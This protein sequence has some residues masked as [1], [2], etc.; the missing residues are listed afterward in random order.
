MTS[1][2]RLSSWLDHHNTVVILVSLLVLWALP[3][4][5]I[6]GEILRRIT[7]LLFINI[8][9]TISLQIFTGNSGVLSFTHYAFVAIGAYMAAIATLGLNQK[10]LAIPQLYP[11]LMSINLP[12]YPALLFGAGAAVLFAALLMYPITRLSGASAVISTFCLLVAFH[13]LL[14]NWE[15]VSNGTRAIFGIQRLTTVLNT[16]AFAIL[17]LV[18]GYWFKESSL[19]L[20]LRASR[21]D[22]LAAKS[23]GIDI[24]RTRYI[25]FLVSIFFTGMAGGLWGHFITTFTPFQFWLSETFTIV[26]MLIIGGSG[27]VSGAVVGT[28]VITIVLEGLRA[29]ENYINLAGVTP[30]PI[31]GIPVVVLSLTMIVI[32]I[33][34]PQGITGGYEIRWAHLQTIV[35]RF[36]SKSALAP[37]EP[38]V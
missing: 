21:E 10:A 30:W 3:V 31:A 11:I 6:G 35:R 12:F 18:V 7:M 37:A 33:L 23:L 14:L 1:G 27:S 4:S 29:I 32:L 28:I 13:F 22:A 17:T 38:E 24:V 15:E 2:N 16:A 26:A 8:G 36:R 20:K 9:L 25:A 34:R 19:G 5:L